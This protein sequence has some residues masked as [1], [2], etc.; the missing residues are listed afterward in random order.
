[1][2]CLKQSTG[3]FIFRRFIMKN[4]EKLVAIPSFENCEEILE[5]LKGRLENKVQ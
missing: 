1:M 5:Y 4:L 2:F 3:N